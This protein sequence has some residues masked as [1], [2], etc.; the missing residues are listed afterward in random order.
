MSEIFEGLAV[1]G[2][3]V[4]EEDRVV[5]LLASLPKSYNVLVTALEVQSENTPCN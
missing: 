3:T 1:I 5:H 4:S 2:D